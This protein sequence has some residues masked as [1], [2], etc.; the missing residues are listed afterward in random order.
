MTFEERLR[1]IRG[2]SVFVV[3]LS[4]EYY[5]EAKNDTTRARIYEAVNDAIKKAVE[6]FGTLTGIK[7]E[8]IK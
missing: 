2:K 7:I 8:S 4:V 1:L 3:A 6:P 5:P